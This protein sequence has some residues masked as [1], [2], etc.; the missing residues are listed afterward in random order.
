M[1]QSDFEKLVVKAVKILPE[2]I[3]RKMENVAIVIEEREAPGGNLLGLYHGIPKIERG[4]GYSMVLPDKITIYKKTIERLA[5]SEKRIPQLVQE[6]VW[7]EIA[8]HFGFNEV[9]VRKLEKK[10]R[11]NHLRK[12]V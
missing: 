10:W 2:S 5:G 11:S 4:T 1:K 8:H 3:Q 12:S 9:E 6:V 7:H